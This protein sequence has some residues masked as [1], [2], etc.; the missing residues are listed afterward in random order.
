LIAV[1]TISS[2]DD[3]DAISFEERLIHIQSQ[4]GF[5]PDASAAEATLRFDL[6]AAL[7]PR[8]VSRATTHDP[9]GT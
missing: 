3:Y 5:D 2:P 1:T 4:V 6:P 9:G 8:A 7:S